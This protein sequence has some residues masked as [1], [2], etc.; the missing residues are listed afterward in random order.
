MTGARAI[1]LLSF[2]V[3]LGLGA[4]SAA[5]AGPPSSA[6]PWTKREYLDFYFSHF[7]GHLALPHLR[8][9]EAKALFN[10]IVDEENILK[11]TASPAPIAER[12]RH[13]AMIL[14]TVGEI[15]A[16]YNYAVLVGEP[17]QEE[18]TRVQVFTLFV[19]DSAIRMA[20]GAAGSDAW[21]TT[22]FGIVASLSERH[23]YSPTQ[24]ETLALALAMHYPAMSRIL[25]DIDKRDF[26]GR[27]AELDEAETDPA[28][29]AA[30]AQLLRISKD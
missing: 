22:F 8:T 9:D 6:G 23:I 18:L 19:L 24:V 7:N 17:L 25:D 20:D 14:M 12:R 29:K 5:E 3:G 13:V 16:A 30:Y 4:P 11:I 15:R 28:V 27:I 1:L 10:R 21:R 2:S 26:R